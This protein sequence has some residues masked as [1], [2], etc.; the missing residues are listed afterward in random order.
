MKLKKYSL[1]VVALLSFLGASAQGVENLRI[2]EVLISNENGI[3]DSYGEKTGWIEIYNDGYVSTTLAGCYISIAPPLGSGEDMFVDKSVFGAETYCIPK[4][5]NNVM[6]MPP[7]AYSLFFTGDSSHSPFNTTF[8]L[9]VKGTIYLW[10]ASGKGV[11]I[12]TFKY[13]FSEIPS[14]NSLAVI[15]GARGTKNV[16]KTFVNPTPGHA[17][18]VEA[19]VSPTEKLKEQD[20]YGFIMTLTA[21]S[22]VFLALMIL[23]LVFRTVGKF[24]QKRDAAKIKAS[25]PKS[26]SKKEVIV[27][28]LSGEVAAAITIALK[29]YQDELEA[30]EQMQLTLNRVAKSYSPWSS[31]IH[32]LTHEPERK[33]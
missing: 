12:D 6:S 28:D 7:R 24:M 32:G 20:K 10:N 17:N 26:Q 25:M 23:Y 8:T 22:V 5:A 1:V 15:R 27:G 33:R 13:D 29:A 19:A 18:Y 21:V 30:E 14:D 9:P 16:I 4:S 2:N 31:K 3:N 11:P